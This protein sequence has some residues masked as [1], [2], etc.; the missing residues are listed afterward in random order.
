MSV[1]TVRPIRFTDHV[2][3]MRS[4]LQVLG[5]RPRIESLGAGWVDLVGETG[6]VAV[7][8]AATSDGGH[9]GGTTLLSFEC[10]D[11]EALA[12]RL[13]RRGF[14]DATVVDDAYGRALHV[15]DPDGALVVADQVQDDLYGYRAV[16]TAG[17][18]PIVVSPVQFTTEIARQATFLT[19]LGL[20]A[21]AGASSSWQQWTGNGTIGLH[22]DEA[23]R[24]I[25]SFQTRNAL[26]ELVSRLI[27]AGFADARSAEEDFGTVVH[28]TDPVDQDVVIV[29][30]T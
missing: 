6:L 19:V 4:F 29:A 22:A 13:R 15:T 11:A 21:L 8:E 12:D 20:R 27:G 10:A 26:T 9:P 28:V 3:Q 23:P 1:V 18:S 2:E 5:L 17:R 14:D 25:L 30:A 7:H 24:T 16:Q